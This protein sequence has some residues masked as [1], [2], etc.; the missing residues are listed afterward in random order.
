MTGN[1]TPQS[2]D[3]KP[4]CGICDKRTRQLDTPDGP[5]RCPACHPLG[6]KPLKQF[7]RCPDCRMEINEWDKSPCGSHTEPRITLKGTVK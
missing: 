3:E 1:A 5:R 6:R 7:R 4:H 2:A